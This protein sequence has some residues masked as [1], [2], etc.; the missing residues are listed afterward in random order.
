MEYL[1]FPDDLIRLQQRWTRAY[2]L[3]A[4]RR[5][6]S[7]A[8]L[9]RELIDLSCRISAHPYWRA[10]GYRSVRLVELRRAAA[11]VPAAREPLPCVDGEFVMS[12]PLET[13]TRSE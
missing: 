11:A 8:G 10:A 12:G 4:V 5:E 1:P 3:L 9:R 7:V 2:H 6:R 13:G